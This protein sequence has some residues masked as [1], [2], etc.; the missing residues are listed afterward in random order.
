MSYTP[1]TQIVSFFSWMLQDRFWHNKLSFHDIFEYLPR[2]VQP[3]LTTSIIYMLSQ[4]SVIHINIIF[5]SELCESG[6]VQPGS[7]FEAG[8]LSRFKSALKR[9]LN[10]H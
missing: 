8:S 4:Q 9:V 1:N 10:I 6:I 5:L 3:A 7:I 2:A